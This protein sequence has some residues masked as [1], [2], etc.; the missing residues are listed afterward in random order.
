MARGDDFIDEGGPVVWP[1]LLQDGNQSQIQFI[2]EEL[3][4]FER[5]VRLR[6]L[7]DLVD[8]EVPDPQA[9][10]AR[11]NLPSSIHNIIEHLKTEILCWHVGS[12][13]QQLV[14]HQPGIGVRFEFVE[15]L[16][17]LFL[18][19]AFAFLKRFD[20]LV[21]LRNGDRHG[22]RLWKESAQ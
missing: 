10:V 9:L 21:K 5:I 16:L 12:L 4:G 7:Q 20:G 11:Q 22:W 17:G 18:N 1:F 8:D 6:D 2:E 15:L 13:L 14:H 19:L 3:V